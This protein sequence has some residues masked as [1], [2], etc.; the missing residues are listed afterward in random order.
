MWFPAVAAKSVRL[1]R[2]RA[3]LPAELQPLDG[4]GLLLVLLVEAV[5]LLA[6]GRAL[7]RQEVRHGLVVRRQHDL[8]AG[9][10]VV[11]DDAVGGRIAA[12]GIV[13]MPLESRKNPLKLL[14]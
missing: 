1:R 6:R 9:E 12:G 13:S 7:Q 2:L 10:V 14:A 3:A 11:V 5:A 8:L 4:L